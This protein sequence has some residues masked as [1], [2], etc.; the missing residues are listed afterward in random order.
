MRKLKTLNNKTGNG[1]K[2]RIAE[3]LNTHENMKNC[4]F[5]SPPGNASGRRRYEEQRENSLSFNLAGKAY[6]IIQECSCSCKNIYFS[7][8]I[9]IDGEKKD[10]RSLKRLI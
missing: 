4:Y 10:I 1:I 6:D 9:R 2:K 3:I 5:W 8:N 7:T